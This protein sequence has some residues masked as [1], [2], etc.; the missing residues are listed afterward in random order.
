MRSMAKRKSRDRRSSS[1]AS[2]SSSGSGSGPRSSVMP[3]PD[4]VDQRHQQDPLHR[5]PGGVVGPVAAPAGVAGPLARRPVEDEVEV[6]V[7]QAE[8]LPGDPLA[9]GHRPAQHLD[10]AQVALHPGRGRRVVAAGRRRRDTARP[11]WPAARRSRPATAGPAR[12]SGGRRRWAR[13]RAR[14]GRPGGP[15]GCRGGRRPGGAPRPSCRCPARPRRR[16]RRAGRSGSPGPARPGWWRR[17]RPSGRSGPCARAASRAASPWRVGLVG[18]RHGV[19]VEDLVVEADDLPAVGQQVPAADDALGVGGGGPVEGLGGRRPPVDQQRLVVGLREAE[20]ADVVAGAVA[21]VEAP[22]AQRA[23][24]RCRGRPAGSPG[25]TARASRSWR[26]W[27]VPPGWPRTRPSSV[28]SL[29][30]HLVEA[31]VEPLDIGAL[32]LEVVGP[33]L[34]RPARICLG[35]LHL[36]A[37]PVETRT[38]KSASCSTPMGPR[39]HAEREAE[40]TAPVRCCSNGGDRP[41]SD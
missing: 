32:G 27:W 30:P 17:C 20:P 9:V 6:V 23:G 14:R 37:R 26:H 22:E 25:C 38:D 41:L 39:D 1:Q 35:Q 7:G 8:V 34:R 2:S 15:G 18:L 31:A 19:E 33:G 5:L 3:R 28:S 12:C 29:R 13:R 16:G 4:L 36:L 10:H 24:R 11:A 21:H 40:E